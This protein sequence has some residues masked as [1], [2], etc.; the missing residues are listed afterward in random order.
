MLRSINRSV[1]RE[2]T[3]R[4]AS[5]ASQ[6]LPFDTL[7]ADPLNTKSEHSDVYRC[8][9]DASQPSVID[10]FGQRGLVLYLGHVRV[11]SSP[12]QSGSSLSPSRGC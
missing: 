5:Q 1:A 9:A 8:S 4:G 11:R 3:A 2:L 6:I 7:L 10:R 12:Q